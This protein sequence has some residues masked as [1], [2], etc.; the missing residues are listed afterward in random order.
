MPELPD[1]EVFRRYMEETSL[2]QEIAGVNLAAPEMLH[3]IDVPGL[4]RNLEGACFISTRRHGKYMFAGTDRGGWLVL[5][6]G[7]TGYLSYFRDQEQDTRH[8][9]M[10]IDFANGWHLAYDCKRKLGEIGYV[11]S[12]ADIAREKEL[13]PDPMWPEFDRDAFDRAVAGRRGS[14]KNLLMNQAVMAGVGNVYSDEILFQAGLHPGTKAEALDPGQ[15]DRLFEALKEVL[16]NAIDS[17]ADPERM[18]GHFLL[19]RR[20]ENEECPACGGSI[21]KVKFSGRSAF[22]CPACQSA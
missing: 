5:H 3:G 2:H 14:V 10:R 17:G 11:G 8:D 6:F 12:P 9:R 13:G 20:R 4:A 16:Q 21:Q 18:P 7:M 22:L 19:P 1:V 15:W